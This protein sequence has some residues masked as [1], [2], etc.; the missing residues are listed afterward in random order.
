MS[1]TLFDETIKNIS[2]DSNKENCLIIS[3][4]GDVYYGL[5]Q[6][7][8]GDVPSNYRNLYDSLLERG[9]KMVHW[10]PTTKKDFESEADSYIQI[11]W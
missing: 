11:S 5:L 4:S 8:T 2:N 1:V 6:C 3:D 9:F 10:Q 7:M